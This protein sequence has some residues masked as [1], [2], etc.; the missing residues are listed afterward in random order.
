MD[1]SEEQLANALNSIHSTLL[2]III[3]IREEQPENEAPQIR[4]TLSG[5]AIDVNKE[6]PEKAPAILDTQ[7]GIM[8]F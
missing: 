5:I 1:L 4:V 2:G 8:V 7:L 6:Q 3:E